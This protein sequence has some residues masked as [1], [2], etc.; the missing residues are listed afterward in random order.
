MSD[1]KQGFDEVTLAGMTHP[2]QS[3]AGLIGE[4]DQRVSENSQCRLDSRLDQALEETFP[5]SDPVSIL[6][7]I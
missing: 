5:A 7:D 4:R 3:E 2:Q 1:P 6:I